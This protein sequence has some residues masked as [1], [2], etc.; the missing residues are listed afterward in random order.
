MRHKLN[1]K[2]CPIEYTPLLSDVIK[3]II[4]QDKTRLSI[5]PK[6]D[7][8][9]DAIDIIKE[10]K[11]EKWVG[12]NDGSLPK[13][14]E[15]KKYA[16]SIPVFW[17]RSA[18][19][20]IDK[21]LIIAHQEGFESIVIHHSGVTKDKTDKIHKAGIEAGAWTINELPGMKALLNKGVNRIYTDYPERLLKLL[22][23][24]RSTQ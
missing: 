4:K 2:V 14:K 15:V 21:D 5:Q 20:D 23:E 6:A 16:K 11:A 17:D 1:K 13:M 7:C 24:R 9:K 10:L 12:F 18:K 3:L 22:D 19:S 8:V